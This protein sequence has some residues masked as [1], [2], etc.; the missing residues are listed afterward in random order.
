MKR[1]KRILAI[2]GVV[3]LLIA[4]CLPMFFAFGEGEDSRSMFMAA[5]GVAIFV[6]VFA[7]IC[8]MAVRIFGKKKEPETGAVK[9]VIFDV[10]RVLVSFDG[11]GY[12]RSFGFPEEEHQRVMDATFRSHV[13]YE[14][15][16]SDRPEEEYVAQMVSAA[17]EYE[18]DIREVMRTSDRS[19]A[20]MDYTVSW[21]QYLKQKGFHLYVLSNYSRYMLEHT[22]EQLDF[23]KYMDGAVFSCNV[24]LLKP[25]EAIYRHLL[26]QYHLKPE[27][28]VFIDD[29][30]E[31][32]D[33]ARAL[34]IK[35]V[36]FTDF[37]QA[38]KE[39]KALGVG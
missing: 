3:L 9:N 27:E 29:T 25:E 31:N 35:T 14:R 16:R 36:H 15:D 1:S 17:P 13:W 21:L 6:P 26:D 28:C 32:C 30:R 22:K 12:V 11:E 2:A 37:Q 34:G 18:A 24:G 33:A 8:M 5:L 10:G 7:Y 23:V 38:A 4:F 19:I 20:V 39:L